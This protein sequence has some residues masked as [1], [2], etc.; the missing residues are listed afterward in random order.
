[1]KWL[2]RE[3]PGVDAAMDSERAIVSS[4]ILRRLARS[5]IFWVLVAHG[6]L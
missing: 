3:A 6:K 2:V 5:S 1:M 4:Q